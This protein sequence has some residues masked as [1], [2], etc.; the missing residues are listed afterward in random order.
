MPV[1]GAKTGGMLMKRL[2]Y[3]VKRNGMGWSVFDASGVKISGEVSA[4]WR[5]VEACEKLTSQAKQKIRKC[6]TGCGKSF[7][8]EGPHHRMC[9]NCRT[10]WQDEAVSLPNRSGS[11]VS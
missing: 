1:G 11:V 4:H 5:A 3:S 8:S 10:C 7:R 2:P 6:I 9:G